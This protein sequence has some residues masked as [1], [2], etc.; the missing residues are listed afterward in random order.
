MC[1]LSKSPTLAIGKRAAD[2]TEE[3]VLVSFVAVENV[4]YLRWRFWSLERSSIRT[5]SMHQCLFHLL[6]RGNM[7]RRSI[8]KYKNCSIIL[9]II[10]EPLNHTM[11]VRRI[12]LCPVPSR[13]RWTITLVALAFTC[14]NGRIQRSFTSIPLLVHVLHS[15]RGLAYN[16]LNLSFRPGDRH[17]PVASSPLTLPLPATVLC[18]PLLWRRLNLGAS[19]VA[20]R[21]PRTAPSSPPLDDTTSSSQPLCALTGLCD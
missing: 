17:V 11:H 14:A 5:L 2:A 6:Q 18:R 15:Q 9:E 8:S 21:L 7:G 19:C 1:G 20:V 13:A 16:S 3:V 10:E 12:G 4:L